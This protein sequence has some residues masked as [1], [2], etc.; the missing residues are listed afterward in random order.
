MWGSLLVAAALVAAPADSAPTLAATPYFRTLDASDG[1]PSSTV[2]KIAQD[3]DGYIWIGTAD[4]L[5]RYD[6]VDFRVFRNDPADAA[7]LSGADV[8]ALF[9]DRDNRIWCGGEDVGLNRLDARRRGFTHFRHAPGDPHS[10]AGNDVWAIAQDAAG[11]IWTGGYA[12]GLDRLD[13]STNKFV[14]FRHVDGDANGLVSDNVLAL[15]GDAAGNLWIGTDAGIDVRG[16]DGHLR[17]ARFARHAARR[18]GAGNHQGRAPASQSLHGHL[19]RVERR[20]G[21]GGR[22]AAGD[23]LCRGRAGP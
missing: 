10:L 6:G 7:S 22:H 2:W 11:A 17:Q 4:G 13:E 1:L 18:G 8:S 20:T 19:F 21:E 3:R 23:S 5:A 15:R 14:H 9:V 12:M 16:H